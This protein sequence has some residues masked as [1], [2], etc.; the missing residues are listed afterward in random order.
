MDN[1][2]SFWRTLVLTIVGVA[3]LSI[4]ALYPPRLRAQ[5]PANDPSRAFDVASIKPNRSGDGATDLG[6]RQ[7]GRFRAINE[8]LFRLIGE[9]YASSFPL[10]RFQV[11]GGPNWIDSD[12]FDV[13]AITD[14]NPSPDQSRLML[15]RLLAERFKLVVHYEMREVPIFNLVI[16][17]KDGRLGPQ[18]RRSDVDCVALR[19]AAGDAPIPVSPGQTR[20][21][22]MR[23]GR[24][25]LSANGMTMA[26]LAGMA[27]SRYVN[28]PVL[29]HTG[30][31]GGFDWTL[32]WTPDTQV[33]ADLERPS[34]F[35]ALQEQLGLK[36]ESL[37]G[38][39]NVLV[40]DS[41]SRPI[42]N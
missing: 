31:D 20:P 12:R 8:T 15:R 14:A 39:V 18:L 9:A 33:V 13:E 30:L 5:A 38:S 3:L 21:C 19:A 23:F 34:I 26:E 16:A 37:D 27:L 35:T 32:E 11:V 22:M 25:Q 2:L 10:P 36:L 7:G 17:R 24:G 4:G 41:A 42:P 1:S 28:R 29:D 6:F 40:I